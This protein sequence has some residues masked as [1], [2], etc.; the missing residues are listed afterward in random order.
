MN[1]LKKEY[2]DLI[3]KLPDDVGSEEIVDRVNAKARIE[4]SRRNIRETGGISFEDFKRRQNERRK[5]LLEGK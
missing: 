2:I 1:M 5:A 3:S 4:A